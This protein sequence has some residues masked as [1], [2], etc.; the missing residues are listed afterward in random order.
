[1]H[2]CICKVIVFALCMCCVHYMRVYRISF[3]LFH[4]PPPSLSLSLSLFQTHTHSLS[5]SLSLSLA[6]RNT[7][8]PCLYRLRWSWSEVL[9]TSPPIQPHL[10]VPHA[11]KHAYE[12]PCTHERSRTRTSMHMLT[13]ARTRQVKSPMAEVANLSPDR[14]S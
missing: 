13:R 10:P 5:L 4:S 14:Q 1:M 2:I 9:P 12:C 8:G 11:H 7:G 6:D 3:Y